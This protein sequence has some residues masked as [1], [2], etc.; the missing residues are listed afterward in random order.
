MCRFG[1]RDLFEGSLG[2]RVDRSIETAVDCLC[3]YLSGGECM[4][5]R[6]RDRAEQ[7]WE[8]GE[9]NL[10]FFLLLLSSSVNGRHWIRVNVRWEDRAPVYV[11]YL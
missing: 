4:R 11:C 8:E 2:T 7:S 10:V 3:R 6:E 1:F 5:E 9:E